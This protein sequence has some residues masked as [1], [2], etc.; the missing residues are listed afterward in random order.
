MAVNRQ[1]GAPPPKR[2]IRSAR[3][4]GRPPSYRELLSGLRAAHQCLI[5]AGGQWP[6]IPGRIRFRLLRC[7]DRITALLARADDNHV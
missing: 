5:D 3:S 4:N 1:S 7:A 6:H 2:N